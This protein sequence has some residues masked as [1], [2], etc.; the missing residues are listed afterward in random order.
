MWQKMMDAQYRQPTG[1]IGR[2]IGSK[3]AKQHQPEMLWTI[4]V[5]DVQPADHILEIGF[6]PGIAVEEAARRASNGFVAG[7]D[8]SQTMVAAALKR[9]RGS[10]VDLRL[11][12]A[13]QLPFADNAFNKVFSIHSIYFWPDP[14]A[15]LA[16]IHRVLKP[17]GRLVLT[18]LPKGKWNPENP[19]LAGTPQC[20]PYTGDE[21]K[22]LLAK[23]G[24]NDLKVEADTNPNLPSNYS[25]IGRR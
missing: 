23:A 14:V 15:V 7:I 2:W 21:L 3:M 17:D 13:A 18:V 8:F 24:F 5:L 9:N 6:G 16:E 4:D 10:N 1:L 11:G 19:E 25:V 12:D 22:R 20:K